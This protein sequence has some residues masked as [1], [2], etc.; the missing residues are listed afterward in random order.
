[1]EPAAILFL[2]VLLL[3]IAMDLGMIISLVRGGDE[4]RQ[5]IVWRASTY[6][7]LGTTGSLVL[8]IVENTVTH[9]Y[10]AVNPFSLLGATALIYF[11][12]LLFFRRKYGG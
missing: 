4:R 8:S 12:L 1:M 11:V 3:I 5:M 2:L 10:Q 6:T 7:L 9:Q